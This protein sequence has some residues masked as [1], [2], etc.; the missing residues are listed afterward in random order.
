MSI[1]EIVTLVGFAIFTAVFAIRRWEPRIVVGV[2]L[3]LLIVAAITLAIGRQGAADQM[4]I[5]AFYFL[6][7]GVI[8]LLIEHIRE[9]PHR[10]KKR[11]STRGRRTRRT[12]R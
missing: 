6:T 5:Y 8:L 9:K 10:E 12:W 11:K 2:T 7:S 1:I 3:A 4:A